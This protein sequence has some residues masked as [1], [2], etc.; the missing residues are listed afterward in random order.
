MPGFNLTQIPLNDDPKS[1]VTNP[2]WIRFFLS[3]VS[4]LDLLPIASNDATAAAAGVAKGGYYRTNADPSII[5][6]R[7]N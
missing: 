4:N 3:L 5:C 1:K 7:V 6:V 2:A